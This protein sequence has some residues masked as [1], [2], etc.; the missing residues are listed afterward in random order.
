MATKIQVVNTKHPRIKLIDEKN[1]FLKERKKLS[2]ILVW[3]LILLFL[4]LLVELIFFFA[5]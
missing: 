3:T 5:G 1:K 4:V 2:N